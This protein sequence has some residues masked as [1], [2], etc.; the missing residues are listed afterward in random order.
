MDKLNTLSG[1]GLVLHIEKG[2]IMKRRQ[3]ACFVILLMIILSAC[4]TPIAPTLPAA[5]TPLLQETDAATLSPTLT[6]TSSLS[7]ATPPPPPVSLFGHSDNIQD[8][9]F[10]PDGK[11]LASTSCKQKMCLQSEVRLWDISKPGAFSQIGSTLQTN[12]Q[13]GKHLAFS[14]NIYWPG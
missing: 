9:A 12:I 7:S 14:H 11:T 4:A 8:I 10:S 13:L 1:A 3:L 6:A 5:K 2:M